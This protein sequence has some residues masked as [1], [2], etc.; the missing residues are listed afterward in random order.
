MT[1]CKSIFKTNRFRQVVQP[2]IEA[3]ASN[4]EVLSAATTLSG[5]L[6]N[7]AQLLQV[8]LDHSANIALAI[9]GGALDGFL[10]PVASAFQTDVTSG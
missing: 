1:N 10:S 7:R 2:G 5:S 9:E 8:W 3:V 6:E 4:R